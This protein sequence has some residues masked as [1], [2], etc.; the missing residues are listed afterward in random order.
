[1][2]VAQKSVRNGYRYSLIFLRMV[3][4]AVAEGSFLDDEH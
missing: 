3:L 2:I 4:E 1:M